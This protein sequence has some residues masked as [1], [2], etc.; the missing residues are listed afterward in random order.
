MQLLAYLL[1][2]PIIW[3]ISILPF[4]V[5]YFFSDIC[6]VIIYHIIGYRRRTVRENLALTLRHLSPAERKVIE[7]KFYRHFTDSFF[8]MAKTLTISDKELE[9]RYVFENYEV[10]NELEAKGK[11]IIM[12]LGH[13]ASYEW[14][15]IMNRRLVSFKGFGVYKVIKNRYFDKLVRKIRGKF[16]TELI[17]TR[18]TIPTMRQNER[19]GILGIYGFVADQSPKLGKAMHWAKFFDMDVPVFTGGEMLAKKLDLNI[20]YVKTSK[21]SRGHYA[22][23]FVAVENI[24]SIPD[25]QITDGFLRMLE[26]Q[27]LEAPEY[28]LWT[29]KRFKHRKNDPA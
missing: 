9:Q 2:Y 23:S 14:L 10:I 27:I 4:R 16:N 25:F 18:E 15:I 29:H 28:Y 13:Y 11:S 22:A 26:Q 20:V 6:Y 12:L 17:G 19:D 21:T 5:L 1:L 7:K 24:Q 8:E 3:F